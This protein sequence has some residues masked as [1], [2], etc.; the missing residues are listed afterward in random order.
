MALRICAG[1]DEPSLS[2]EPLHLLWATNCERRGRG[3]GERD[4]ETEGELE[5][6]KG[7][8]GCYLPTRPPLVTFHATP[9]CVAAPIPAVLTRK[10]PEEQQTDPTT[11]LIISPCLTSAY[12]RVDAQLIVSFNPPKPPKKWRSNTPKYKATPRDK[13]SLVT[14]NIYTLRI[15]INHTAS[16]ISFML[17]LHT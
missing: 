16:H 13:E 3:D 11:G 12:Y 5:V 10:A 14:L 15:Q 17:I 9:T 6:E 1:E 2:A 8:G 4:G 7:C